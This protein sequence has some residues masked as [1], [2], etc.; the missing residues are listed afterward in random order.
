MISIFLL[1]DAVCVS[2]ECDRCHRL[3]PFGREFPLDAPPEYLEAAGRRLRLWSPSGGVWGSALRHGRRRD[4][5]T[6]CWSD[7]WGLKRKVK[8]C[9][10]RKRK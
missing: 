6:A 9:K 3:S 2:L 10:P 5:C 4:F 7:R 8:P 1:D